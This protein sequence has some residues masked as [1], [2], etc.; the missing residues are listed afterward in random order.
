MTTR[1]A[2]RLLPP[3]LTNQIAAGEVVERPSSVL[4]ELVENSLD[5]GATTVRVEVER[6]GQGLIRVQDDGHGMAPDELELAVTR[7]ATSKVQAVTDLANILSFGFRGEALASIGSVA[8]LKVS[9]LA[10]GEAEGAFVAVEYGRE[11]ERGPA[12]L[13]GGTTI[14]VRD[15]FANVPARLKFLKTEATETRHCQEAVARLAL[16]NLA[17]GFTVK[18]GSRTALRF[19]KNQTLAQRLAVLWP[20]AVCET[21]FDVSLEGEGMHVAGVAGDP[22]KAQGRADRMLFFV[23]DRPVSDKVLVSAV[24][25]AYKGRLLAREYPQ[26]ALFLTLPPDQVD[27]NVHPAKREVRFRDERSVFSLVRA[28]VVRALDELPPAAYADA[29]RSFA[30]Y[31]RSGYQAREPI[32]SDPAP[33]SRPRAGAN[34]ARAKFAGYDEYA[35]GPQTQ[36]SLDVAPAPT[37]ASPKSPARAEAPGAG[38][39]AANIAYLGQV[40]DTYLVLRLEDGCLG[41]LDQHAAHERVIFSSLRAEATRG[42][43][44]PLAVP[45]TLPLH[46]SELDTLQDIWGELNRLGFELATETSTLTVTG[47]PPLL[48]PGRA[49]QYLQDVLSGQAKDASD[50]WAMLSCKAAIK[51]GTKLAADEALSLIDAWAAAKD[52]AYCPHGRPALVRLASRELERLFKRT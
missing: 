10:E 11:L 48:T 4:K 41:L 20:P 34:A 51:A 7:H 52:R 19:P 2:I 33:R 46:A 6:G 17:A 47:V 21:L 9:S 23:N 30:A 32:P 13:S 14:E 43:T 12:A 44:H 3:E 5:A 25:E 31:G 45:L 37:S 26:V 39:T 16:A 8:R 28:G 29:E 18:V 22:M 42:E 24:R 1:R 35:K 50:L 49:K 36:A 40:E 38:A 15:L 27:V